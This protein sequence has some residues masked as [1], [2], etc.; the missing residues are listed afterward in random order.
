MAIPFLASAFAIVKYMIAFQRLRKWMPRIHCSSAALI[1]VMGI[2]LLTG[3]LVILT[4][5]LAGMF[6]MFGKIIM[7][8]LFYK[9]NISYDAIGIIF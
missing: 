6:P 8:F 4:N 7:L 9:N 3:S 1:I 5:T 2:L